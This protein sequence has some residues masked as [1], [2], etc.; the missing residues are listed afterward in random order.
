M[1][2]KETSQAEEGLVHQA[3]HDLWRVIRAIEGYMRTI[4]IRF[5]LTRTQAATLWE[6]GAR[7]PQSLKALASHTGMDSST[8]V[9]VIDRLCLKG[10]VLRTQG[11]EDRRQV[12]LCLSPQ[13]QEVLE[14]APHPTQ[15]FLVWGIRQ[16]GQVHARDLRRSVHVLAD[17]LEV[18]STGS[19]PNPARD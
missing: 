12:S 3:S 7:G 5:D 9:G 13:G 15:G 2:S 18:I 4:E 10:M 17:A 1:V 16:I 11:H 8:L 19:P 14:A 6:L